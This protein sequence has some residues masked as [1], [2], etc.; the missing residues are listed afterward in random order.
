M[1]DNT[2]FCLRSDLCHSW[3]YKL[4]TKIFQSHDYT[5]KI[6]L[7]KY[8]Y[9]K[10]G[11]QQGQGSFFFFFCPRN[12]FLICRYFFSQIYIFSVNIFILF[13]GFILFIK[14]SN[15]P[16]L[17]ENEDEAVCDGGARAPPMLAIFSGLAYCF[18]MSVFNQPQYNW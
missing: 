1:L 14:I 15:P 17:W 6:F 13:L 16:D 11:R 18:Y 2:R 5:W 3:A 4:L 9:R 8:S 12:F 7:T 10:I